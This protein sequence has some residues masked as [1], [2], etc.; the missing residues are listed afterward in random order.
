ME[1]LRRLMFISG[2]DFYVLSYLLLT[3][4]WFFSNDGGRF[5]DHRKL[6][7]ILHL[8]SD[9]RL[10]DLIIR[11]EGR[12]I[13]NLSDKEF[14]F[15][16]YSK[17]E[18]HKR[19]INKLLQVFERKKYINLIPTKNPSIYDVEINSMSFPKGLFDSSRFS[20]EIDSLALLKVN[21]KRLRSL[22]LEKFLERVYKDKGINVWPI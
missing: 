18:L 22:G 7:Y 15:S 14:L 10:I 11:Y 12:E 19:E 8:I 2:E 21:V 17:S 13:K 5:K 16:S 6:T 4:L 9:K 3:T 20:A 1:K